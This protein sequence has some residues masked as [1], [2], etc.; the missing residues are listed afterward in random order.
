MTRGSPLADGAPRTRFAFQVTVAQRDRHFLKRYGPTSA[1]A[2]CTT[3]RSRVG[4]GC[5]R[6]RTR[7]HLDVRSA[8]ESCRSPTGSCCRV[9]SGD[10]PSGGATSWWRANEHV[11]GAGRLARCTG[12]TDS[13]VVEDFADRTT[14]VQPDTDPT[15]AFVAGFMAAESTFVFPS[16]RRF[17]CVV[18][19]GARDRAA[20]SCCTNTSASGTCAGS[21]GAGRA[22][23][24]RSVG[25]CAGSG[26][27]SA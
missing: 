18:A 22:T 26:T 17:A 15:A 12:A 14:P 13:C 2:R 4:T 27:S 1:S 23:T 16:P 8:S 21:R 10:S 19:L 3:S 20:S 5:P 9:P 25:P 11:G 7:S 24:M 6:R